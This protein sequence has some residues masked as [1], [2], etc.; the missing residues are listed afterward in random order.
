M[1]CYTQLH[2]SNMCKK[3][4][5]LRFFCQ[6]SISLHKCGAHTR[7]PARWRMLG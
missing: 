4:Q 1:S 5:A 3:R 7:L 6:H 2:T